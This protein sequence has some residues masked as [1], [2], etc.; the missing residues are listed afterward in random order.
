MYQEGVIA[1]T[2]PNRVTWMSGSINVPG[3]PQR[4][5]QGGNTY[6]DKNETPGCEVGVINCYPLKWKTTAQIYEEAGVT[7]AGLPVATTTTTTLWH[8]SSSSKRPRSGL[9]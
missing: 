9:H 8:G 7:M 2:N 4:P 1:S 3:G 6:I 5:D